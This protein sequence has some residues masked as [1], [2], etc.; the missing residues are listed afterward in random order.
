MGNPTNDNNKPNTTICAKSYSKQSQKEEDFE[1]ETCHSPTYFSMFTKTLNV[2]SNSP[3]QF[4]NFPCAKRS[5][6][7]Q[8][9]P[10]LTQDTIPPEL[11]PGIDNC[12]AYQDGIE[13]HDLL[14]NKTTAEQ[15]AV[16]QISIA[17]HITKLKGSIASRSNT[18]CLLQES[19]LGRV[20]PPLSEDCSVM[21][22]KCRATS[23][24]MKSTKY[25]CNNIQRILELQKKIIPRGRTYR[26]PL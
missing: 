6:F 10:P 18:S 25:K 17:L 5:G 20:L 19:R 16:Q 9:K 23:T 3:Q 24:H 14:P 2:P 15:A 7:G 8:V 1:R 22:V 21:I 13:L 11:L 12:L 26:Y 4:S